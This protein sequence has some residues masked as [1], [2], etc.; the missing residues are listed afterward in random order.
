M[1]LH[2]PPMGG[3][4]TKLND[5]IRTLNAR[6]SRT[7][8]LAGPASEWTRWS[9][10]TEQGFPHVERPTANNPTTRAWTAGAE[11]PP[12][13]GPADPTP[14]SGAGQRFSLDRIASTSYQTDWLCLS[15]A[16]GG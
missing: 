4:G 2:E 3:Y 6:R 10:P 9:E 5:G 8:T 12:F 7:R 16:A 11:E 1:G 15:P 13:M 14:A